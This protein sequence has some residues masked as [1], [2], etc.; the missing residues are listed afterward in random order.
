VVEAGPEEKDD[1]DNP[2]APKYTPMQK[3]FNRIRD[4]M[5][6]TQLEALMEGKAVQTGEVY[7]GGATWAAWQEGSRRFLVQMMNRRCA[8][9]CSY[10]PR[11]PESRYDK[12]QQ[13][14]VGMSKDQVRKLLGVSGKWMGS[15]KADVNGGTNVYDHG[16]NSY[17][18]FFVDDKVQK[19]LK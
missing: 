1:P 11:A 12:F 19:I 13:V 14:T 15:G 9:Q 4:L 18:I 5:T 16:D 10:D 17:M 6:M 3:K 7:P 2:D 8:L